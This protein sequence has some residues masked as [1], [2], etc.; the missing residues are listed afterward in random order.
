VI[1]HALFLQDYLPSNIVIA[2]W[3]LGVE[4][5]SYI[6]APFV[7]VPLLQLNRH[8]LHYG[9]VAALILPPPLA[10]RL[11]LIAG[12]AVVADYETFLRTIRSPFHRG[13]GGLAIGVLVAL[14]W[15]DRTHYR[16]IANPHAACVIFWAGIAVTGGFWLTTPMLDTIGLFDRSLL[17]LVL[18]AGFGAVVLG[19]LMRGQ[20]E[21]RGAARMLGAP[22]LQPVAI[23]S[24]S[25]Y[26]V[27]MT[28][29][30]AAFTSS[31]G[32]NMAIIGVSIPNIC[33]FFVFYIGISILA[34]LILHS[35]SKS[36][37]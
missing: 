34:A 1:Y 5:K 28:V 14:L 6:A 11:N 25:L 15:R 22:V 20:P 12:S 26:L 13:F 27:H 19:A 10:F 3:S 16:R 2:F 33:M 9:I 4:E 21:L 37:F 17:Q 29:I 30:P 7:L 35:P 24:Y 18:A 23:L 8:G 31:K 36:R 32:L